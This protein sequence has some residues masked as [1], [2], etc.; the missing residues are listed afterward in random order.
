[1]FSLPWDTSHIWGLNIKHIKGNVKKD[2]LSREC[3]EN[4][5]DVGRWECFIKKP[6]IRCLLALSLQTPALKTELK[7][8][9]SSVN[10]QPRGFILAWRVIIVFNILKTLMM[11]I[12]ANLLQRPH[13]LSE[14][15][16]IQLLTVCTQP[17][18]VSDGW[19]MS[20][21]VIKIDYS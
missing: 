2:G 5:S 14:A 17:C 4:R 16:M 9:C 1:M 13:M 11:H 8:P 10:H 20:L 6:Q 21:K 7:L 3:G 19:I 15:Y 18:C 12:P